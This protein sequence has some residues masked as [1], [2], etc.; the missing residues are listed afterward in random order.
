MRKGEIYELQV[1]D[2]S[3]DGRGIGRAD[4]MVTFV[5]GLVPGDAARV[6]VTKVKKHIAEGRTEEL[7]DP[8][9]HRVEVPCRYFSQCGGCAMQSLD[10]GFQVELK[11]DQVRSQ[12][13]RLYGGPLP[14]FD[15][16]VGMEH[17]WRYRN[18]TEYGLFAGSVLTEE[19]TGTAY[20]TGK[21]RVGYYD[22]GSGKVTDV[23]E[24]LLQ[25]EAAEMAAYGLRRYIRES[26]MTVY[27]PK[28]RRGKLRRMIVRTGF[29]SGEVMVILVVNG[30]KIK[31][32][33]L[34]AEI[35][36]EAV[37]GSGEFELCSIVIEYNTN[38]NV[39]VPGKFEVIAGHRTIRD[40]VAG[41]ELEISPQSFYQ[42]NPEMMEPLY[43]TVLEY[44][45]LNGSEVIY[46]L[47]CGA[48]TIGLFCAE[49]AKYVWG[50]ETVEQAILDANRNAVLNGAVNIQFLHGKAE[51]KIHELLEHSVRPDVVILD[52]PR[53]GCKPEL[54]ETI[55]QTGPE[56]IIY[57]SCDPATQ[58]RDLRILAPE[59]GDYRVARIRVIDQFCHTMRT[60]AVVLLSRRESADTADTAVHNLRKY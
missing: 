20:N 10:Y 38:R 13:Q 16:P 51:E 18:K 49:H 34:L 1:T 17:P 44:A 9:P 43:R 42:V 7:L 50:I 59:G 54:M 60:E 55:L 40:T 3:T 32:P 36:D 12:M 25:S 23:R 5:P 26:G 21:L 47:Y 6:E 27:D 45:E 15:E 35:L 22:R 52:P 41:L 19:K 2:L 53:S 37:T 29:S 4:G 14:E 56:K 30:K 48:G 28:T 57:V 46:D 33:E 24:C 39:A 8:S 58:A 11:N 31:N